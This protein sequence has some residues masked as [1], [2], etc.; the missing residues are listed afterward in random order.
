MVKIVGHISRPVVGEGRNAP[1]RQMFFVN[2]RPC[3]LPQIAK[4]I[5]EVYKGF[6]VTQ[7]PFI[8]ADIQLDTGKV[9]MS[10]LW[11]VA[12]DVRCLRRERFPR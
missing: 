11:G 2:G 4:A 1:D 8:F 6:N 5:N 9:G 12:N 10:D 7:S 3:V